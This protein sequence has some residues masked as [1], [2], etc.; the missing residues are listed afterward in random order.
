VRL[1]SAQL[2]ALCDF[3]E[4][5]ANVVHTFLLTFLDIS[6]SKSKLDLEQ[7]TDT[8]LDL[9]DP[10]I[11]VKFRGADRRVEV[12]MSTGAEGG[13]H[14]WKKKT[15]GS[16]A[17]DLT[18]HTALMQILQAGLEKRLLVLPPSSPDVTNRALELMQELP[19][20]ADRL[21]RV[22]KTRYTIWLQI[23]EFCKENHVAVGRKET[24]L[25]RRA[26]SVV[27]EQADVTCFDHNENDLGTYRSISVE[28]KGLAVTL[29]LFLKR[30]I[31]REF[32]EKQIDY[33]IDGYPG[34]IQRV[35]NGTMLKH[36]L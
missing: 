20:F 4:L 8:Y 14:E 31:L 21:V 18:D 36:S 22:D 2:T 25:L 10:S 26:G 7:R 34:F 28:G 1:F 11:G 24:A 13:I 32:A 23:P 29:A 12:K 3:G 17:D 30:T 33:L 16:M 9:G 15:Y 27:I 6:H 35:R 19:E 5:T